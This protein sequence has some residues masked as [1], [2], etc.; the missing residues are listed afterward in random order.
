MTVI[1]GDQTIEKLV[2][3]FNLYISCLQHISTVD[4]FEL[5]VAISLLRADLV[6]LLE[7]TLKPSIG[8]VHDS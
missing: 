7:L 5:L 8:A 6:V 4:I 2:H 3:D 1:G